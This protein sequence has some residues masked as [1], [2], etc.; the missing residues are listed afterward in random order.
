MAVVKATGAELRHSFEP[1]GIRIPFS[2]RYRWEEMICGGCGGMGKNWAHVFDTA[3]DYQ[4]LTALLDKY[5]MAGTI[6][7]IRRYGRIS[8]ECIACG[9][10]KWDADTYEMMIESDKEIRRTNKEVLARFKEAARNRAPRMAQGVL[11]I[12]EASSLPYNSLPG[13]IQATLE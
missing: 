12:A 2:E 1:S 4:E 3:K 7:S 13:L 10:V 11:P 5:H 6:I 9:H 8:K